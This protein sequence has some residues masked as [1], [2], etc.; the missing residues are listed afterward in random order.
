M[1]IAFPLSMIRAEK[2]AT[3]GP[4]DWISLARLVV[5]VTG[6]SLVIRQLARIANASQAGQGHR[7]AD[8]EE[9]GTRTAGSSS[10]DGSGSR[11]DRA[12]S[13]HARAWRRAAAMTERVSAGSSTSSIS[14]SDAALSALPRS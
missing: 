6:F 10:L 5:S 4:G 13:H 9:T 2:P 11:H 8:R 1:T 12:Q 7:Q 14:K 3:M